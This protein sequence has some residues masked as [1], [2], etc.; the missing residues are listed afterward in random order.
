MKRFVLLLLA[1]W[2]VM[3]TAQAQT[4]VSRKIISAQK[5]NDESP[6][7][8]QA[9]PGKY[10]IV[11]SRIVNSSGEQL[12][13]RVVSVNGNTAGAIR[14]NLLGTLDYPFT[15]HAA[16]ALN[17]GGFVTAA[18][19]LSDRQLVLRFFNAAFQPRGTTVA[20]GITGYSPHLIQSG[21]GF[22]MV[23]TDGFLQSFVSSL[24]A[25]GKKSADPV[26][27]VPPIAANGF[28]PSRILV[29]P[30]GGFVI[31]GLERDAGGSKS[32]ASS[33][34]VAVNL[35]TISKPIAHESAFASSLIFSDAAFSGQN[36]LML[37]GHAVNN[38][39]TNLSMRLL[40]TKGQNAGGIKKLN[41]GGTTFSRYLRIVSLTGLNK[42][43][44]S[45]EDEH[46]G[47]FFLQVL[48]ANGTAVSDP[49]QLSPDSFTHEGPVDLAWDENSQTL[50][51]AWTENSAQPAPHKNI[52]FAIFKINP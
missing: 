10:A 4:V 38:S 35:S 31:A 19:R 40:G 9:G 6:V 42:Y 18:T 20:T 24:D 27:V 26:H 44:V 8:V 7:L 51:A 48:N 25:S 29:S 3:T 2:L 52:W 11:W 37:F 15:G 13:F 12:F 43:V 46:A 28:S 16:A 34:F 39:Q 41:T 17:G 23:N 47:L 1:C 5:A 49:F 45:W 30:T 36:A 21:N 32:R 22:L 33:F 14:N 50:L